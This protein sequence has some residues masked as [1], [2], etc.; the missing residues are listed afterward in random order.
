MEIVFRQMLLGDIPY[1][2]VAGILLEANTGAIF[3]MWN[4]QVS[5]RTKHIDI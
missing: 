3:L 5:Q 4:H 1:C 2:D